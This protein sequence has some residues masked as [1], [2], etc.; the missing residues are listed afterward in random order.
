MLFRLPLAKWP[1]PAADTAIAAAATVLAFCVAAWGWLAYIDQPILEAHAFRQ[2]QTALTSYWTMRDGFRLAYETPVLGYPWSIPFEFP[3]YQWVVVVIARAA[4]TPLS[5]T[6]R[7]VS[8]A[9]FLAS[10]I[11]VAIIVRRA[12][13]PWRVWFAF[14]A[15]FLSS[16]LYL[17][18]GRTF[19]IETAA[20]CFMLF[21]LA[22]G[23]DVVRRTASWTAL[24]LAFVWS[25][26]ALL[27]KA[28]TALPI[29][30][31]LIVAWLLVGLSRAEPRHAFAWRDWLKLSIAWG[32]PLG[33]GAMW[34]IYSDSIRAHNPLAVAS[35][36]SHPL[37]VLLWNF[38][39]P[40]Q[41]VS[42]ALWM[43]VVLFRGVFLNAGI[44]LGAILVGAALGWRTRNRTRWLMAG[45]LAA[46]FAGLLIF[47]NLHI[48]H[49][50]YQ[51]ASTVFLIAAVAVAIGEWLP[52]AVP[53]RFVWVSVLLAVVVANLYQFSRYELP[54]MQRVLSPGTNRT[55]RLQ[56]NSSGLRRSPLPFSST[57]SNGA[58]RSRT[59]LS[60]RASRFPIF[61]PRSWR[62]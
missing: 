37:N 44:G 49:D 31:L 26:L 7:S 30:A 55:L 2:T 59:M 38:G 51:V 46:Y 22:Y 12:D 18:W 58:A 17:F 54:R 36:S 15:L 8:F 24:M 56:A 52:S 50:Y 28:T 27:Q 32:L 1:L 40:E 9:F 62:P 33:I 19:M 20:T 39:I 43:D 4:G 6:G 10:L 57:A 41:R 29:V 35:T 25:T 48:V 23:L 11:P 34:S 21:A 45:A 61:F 5:A 60:A 3:L 16:P 47:T 42:K 13:L 53:S 14:S